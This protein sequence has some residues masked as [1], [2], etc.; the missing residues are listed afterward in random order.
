MAATTTENN[1]AL[2][3]PVY[4]R[5]YSTQCGNSTGE[6]AFLVFSTDGSSGANHK[7]GG[8]CAITTGM[9]Q[10]RFPVNYPGAKGLIVA[11]FNGIGPTS[12]YYGWLGIKRSGS[13]EVPLG[14]MST[15]LPAS[16]GVSVF[17]ADAKRGWDIYETTA[18]MQQTATEN[19]TYVLGPVDLTRNYLTLGG[20]TSGAA[21]DKGQ[22]FIQVTGGQSSLAIKGSTIAF[23]EYSTNCGTCD[24]E[25]YV[26]FFEVP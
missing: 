14:G 5:P 2:P 6:H 7:L 25:I 26:A 19:A 13:G 11:V 20:L 12:T 21:I 9:E 1:T 16:V 3:S 24:D 4:L 23:S 17:P 18:I 15:S 8:F 10:V 22:L